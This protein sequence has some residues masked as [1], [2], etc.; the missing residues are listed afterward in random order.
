MDNIIYTLVYG[1]Q[2]ADSYIKKKINDIL[3]TL[4]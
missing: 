2:D 3:I 4:F 1:A